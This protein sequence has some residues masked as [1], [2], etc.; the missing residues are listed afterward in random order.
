MRVS[1]KSRSFRR[2]MLAGAMAAATVPLIAYGATAPAGRDGPPQPRQEIDNSRAPLIPFETEE[3]GQLPNGR[4]WGEI[5]GVA[6][7]SK[8]NVVI[9]NHP[10]SGTVGPLYGNA[11][12]ELFEFDSRGR[13][14][15]EIGEK[16]YGLG[17]AHQVRFDKYDNLWV[18]DKGTNQV[19]K[20]APNGK[21]LMNLGRRDE[22]FD[23]KPGEHLNPAEAVPVD[24]WFRGPTDVAWDPDDNIFVSDGYINS[25]IAK[26]SKE[27]DWIKSWGRN[28]RGGVNANENPGAISNPHSMVTDRQGNV[29]VGD[30][31]NRRIQVFDK[32]GAFLRFMFLNVP[33]DKRQRPVLGNMPANPEARPDQTSPWTMC[34]T[35]TPTE[36][37]YIVDVEPGRLYKMTLDG[38]IVG[39]L[40]KSGR[41]MGE[42]NWAHSLACPSENTVYVADMNNW[43]IQK[44]TLHPERAAAPAPRR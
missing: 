12:T 8:G 26:I 39:M 35:N 40:G 21:V 38:R 18:I 5:L 27:G 13:F 29:Y 11:T 28:G 20:F 1:V 19:I 6:V 14:I 32:E 36:Y 41:R 42:F 16:V 24:G 15:R 37:L 2:W 43:R 3:F 25:R 34:I 4:N 22:G 7:N 31:G 33:Y 44:L 9:L 17:Y 23:S 30:R 10:G